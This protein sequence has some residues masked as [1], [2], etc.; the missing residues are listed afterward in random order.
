MS[1]G[2]SHSS[3]RGACSLHQRVRLGQLLALRTSAAKRGNDLEEIADDSE[4]RDLEDR[5]VRIAVDRHDVV[6]TLHPDVVLHRATD[7]DGDVE[8]R[9]DRP[10]RL[11]DLLV[12]RSPSG[13]DDG[14]RCPN[15]RAKRLRQLLDDGEVS[16]LLEPPPSTHDH[17]SRVEPGGAGPLR[18]RLDERHALVFRRQRHVEHL[19]DRLGQTGLRFRETPGSHRRH[20]WVHHRET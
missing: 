8:A 1:R 20:D 6:R 3:V 5:R 19:D 2:R 18:R 4:R 10:S 7:A 11:A 16:G 12:V 9:R 14:P 17:V 13:I 15:R